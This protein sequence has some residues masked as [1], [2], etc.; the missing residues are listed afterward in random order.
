V[1]FQFFVNE[2][3]DHG[4]VDPL[5][6]IRRGTGFIRNPAHY[7]DDLLDPRRRTHIIR[8]FLEACRLG[9]EVA[10]PGEERNDLAVDLVYLLADFFD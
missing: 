10:A 3:S 2:R 5:H 1:G 4:P 7:A 9:D 6:D 8:G